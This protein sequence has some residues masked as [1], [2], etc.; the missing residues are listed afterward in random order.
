MKWCGQI[1]FV[2]TKELENEPGIWKEVITERKYYGDILRNTRHA[3]SSE[4]LND[5]FT[6][7]NEFSVLLDA[8]AMAN[9]SHIRYLE[10]QGVKWKIASVTIDY[11]RITLT[12]GGVYNGE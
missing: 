2:E 11:P 1:G 12:T 5:N 4:Y 9:Y 3:N 8:F 6:I 10:F 7:N